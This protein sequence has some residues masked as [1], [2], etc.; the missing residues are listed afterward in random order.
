[1]IKAR[2]ILFIAA[3]LVVAA[4]AATLVSRYL[5][6]STPQRQVGV[7]VAAADIAAGET[8]TREKLKMVKR[9]E[10]EVPEDALRR[11]EPAVGRVA[12]GRI[13]KGEPISNK[14]LVPREEAA[15]RPRAG[16]IAQ[17][18][19]AFSMEIDAM[20]GVSGRLRPKDRVDVVAVN[21]LSNE[22]G[23]RIARVILSNVEIL[24]IY[25]E[26]E[27]RRGRGAGGKGT[28]TLLLTEEETLSLAASQ[29]ARLRL[30]QRNPSDDA[31]GKDEVTVFSVSLGPKTG[32]EMERMVA[33]R[34]RRLQAA[35]DK[36]M[37]AVT[38]R[39]Q[40]EDGI[41]GLLRPGDRV[42][43]I[44][45][46]A[47]IEAAVHGKREP[48][49]KATVTD[50][51]DVS[52]V[53]MQDVEVLFVE[54]DVALTGEARP[55][56]VSDSSPDTPGGEKK[57]S[58]EWVS[59]WPTKRVTLLLSPEDAEKLTVI[60]TTSDKI[61]LIVRRAGDEGTVETS[62]AKSNEV[63]FKEEELFY[64][65]TIFGRGPSMWKKPFD[66]KKMQEEDLGPYVH[67]P[68]PAPAL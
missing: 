6:K 4:L 20:S 11:M 8:L 34:N 48:G 12:A 43:V 23:D 33:E 24:K 67:E 7:L 50:S 42:D 59:P 68:G 57:A 49:A 27:S 32:A 41:C 10:T 25:L 58:V 51:F 44:G 9:P 47:F 3:A 52:R 55:T 28:V 46:H 18:M 66:R 31:E 1:M 64:D 22:K 16:E 54:E 56:R 53:L 15:K 2:G 13:K 35:I 30:I 62:G 65:I 5:N 39:V 60:A 61:K 26:Q 37:R 21:Q 36:G 38:I 45:T 63:F 14:R 29:G 40:D 17:G 19:R